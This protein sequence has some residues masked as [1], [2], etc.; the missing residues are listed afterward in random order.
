M[1]FDIATTH[2]EDR[3]ISTEMRQKH[4]NLDSMPTEKLW[5]LHEQVVVELGRKLTA[6]RDRLEDRLRRL[7]AADTEMRHQRLPKIPPKYRNPTNG[8]QTWAGRG[9]QPRWLAAQLQTGKKLSDF[10]IR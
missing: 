1:L 8:S 9:K 4:F 7:G 5:E 2:S 6:E 3:P 10:L